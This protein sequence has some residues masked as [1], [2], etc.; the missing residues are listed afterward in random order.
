M[1]SYDRFMD[2]LVDWGGTWPTWRGLY[3]P[4]DAPA[5]P[6]EGD[7][8]AVDEQSG[9]M[10]VSSTGDARELLGQVAAG[11]G[12]L[13]IVG[14]PGSGKTTLLKQLVAAPGTGGRRY[15]FFFDLSLKRREESFADF[16]TRTLAPYMHVEAAYVFPVFCY[17]TR[18]GAL[19]SALDGF[20][21]AVPDLTQEGLLA[22]FTEV[23][24][25]LSAESAVV[26]TSRVSFL[27]DS[28]QVRRLLDGTKLMSEKL[29]QQLH[30]Q[31]VD[32]LRIPRFSVL[33][34]RDDAAGGSLL[35]EQLR[36]E[37]AGKR[38]DDSRGGRRARQYLYPR[39]P[40]VVAHQSGGGTAVAAPGDQVLRTVLPARCD[41][42]HAGRACE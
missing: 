16:V 31:G 19:L 7:L 27:E 25:V 11:G 9:E 12:N 3:P 21:E 40:A 41:C 38:A 37:A 15:R 26:M 30:A 6:I 35:A 22:F 14:R 8:L 23:S 28:P 33:R 18:S 24:Q 36:R 29:A 20:D 39:G 34:L 13:L 4:L 2:A 42:V 5:A 10:A 17:F 1:V 32:P